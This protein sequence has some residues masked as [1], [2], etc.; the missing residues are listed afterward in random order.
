MSDELRGYH[1]HHPEGEQ[2]PPWAHALGR[3]LDLVLR[4]QEVIMTALSDLQAAIAAEDTEIASVVAFL[5]GLPAAIAADIAAAAGDATALA[6]ISTDVATQTQGL[7]TA[8]TTG[9]GAANPAPAP[10]A[11]P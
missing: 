9:Q 7:V 6:A 1:H 2:V 5:N 4:T 11:K 10:Q 3:K 8:L